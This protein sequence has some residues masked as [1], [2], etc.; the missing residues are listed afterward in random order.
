M[1]NYMQRMFTIYIEIKYTRHLIPSNVKYHCGSPEVK[2]WHIVNYRSVLFWKILKKSIK[3]FI[4]DKTLEATK[5]F[6]H[7]PIYV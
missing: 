3:E 4:I 5:I 1:K 2:T 6:L 7:F